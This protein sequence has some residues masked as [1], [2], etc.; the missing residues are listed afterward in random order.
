MACT[1]WTFWVLDC[2]PNP[3][4][5][6]MP[7]SKT[8]RHSTCFFYSVVLSN[9][10]CELNCNST[11]QSAD[12]NCPK[13]RSRPK[14]SLSTQN[15][16]KKVERKIRGC[17]FVCPYFL[18]VTYLSRPKSASCI[19]HSKQTPICLCHGFYLEAAHRN[20]IN[21]A[22]S[23]FLR[24]PNLLEA[25]N[26]RKQHSFEKGSVDKRS[27]CCPFRE[28]CFLQRFIFIYI[29]LGLDKSWLCWLYLQLSFYQKW[30]KNAH[31]RQEMK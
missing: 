11:R 30:N 2:A 17:N 27:F 5:G 16:Q 19:V 20:T 8:C 29:F 1:I 28:M 22:D 9:I 3:F 25:K 24:R 4:C 26:R 15:E 7:N 18:H 6:A 13:K 21:L 14:I 12:K 23:N 10:K 31:L